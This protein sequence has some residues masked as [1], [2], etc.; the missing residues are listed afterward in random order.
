MGNNHLNSII[1]DL[2]KLIR[3][4]IILN[5]ATN[6]IRLLTILN[7]T[8]NLIIL[9]IIVVKLLIRRFCGLG[10]IC[11]VINLIFTHLVF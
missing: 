8:T 5:K 1:I 4:L 7:K 3:L 6:R 9:L 11:K 2:F 10:C